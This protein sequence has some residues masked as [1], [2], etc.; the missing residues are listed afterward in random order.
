MDTQERPERVLK[1]FIFQRVF[2]E[3]VLWRPLL[4]HPSFATHF[5][6]MQYRIGFIHVL[7]A[8]I[9]SML[10][11]RTATP[12]LKNERRAAWERSGTNQNERRAAW[13]RFSSFHVPVGAPHEAPQKCAK[14]VI[15]NHFSQFRWSR[16]VLPKRPPQRSPPK[17]SETVYFKR[18]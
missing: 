6:N 17:T 15:L 10:D 9:E 11:H 4:A 16:W 13:E 18:F 7:D 8:L 14:P 12:K 1:V 2:N 5:Q 3:F